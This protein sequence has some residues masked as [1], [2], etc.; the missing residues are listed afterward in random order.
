M[1]Q[2][3]E[4]SCAVYNHPKLKNTTITT[5]CACFGTV[6]RLSV[7]NIFT[8]NS[9]DLSL[10]DFVLYAQL[11]PEI[12]KVICIWGGH[13]EEIKMFTSNVTS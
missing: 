9:S 8:R 6:L 7:R 2:T 3:Q 13:F 1:G 12:L 5:I 10:S 4:G 11:L